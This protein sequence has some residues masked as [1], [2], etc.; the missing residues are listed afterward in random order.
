MH[1]AEDVLSQVQ[2][3][4][5]NLFVVTGSGQLSLLDRLQSNYPGFFA[6]GHIIS[7][8]DVRHGK[9]SPEP[10]LKGLERANVAPW[11]AVVVENA[12]LGVR[13]RGRAH[14]H[15]C[16]QYRTSARQRLA[17]RRSRFAILQHGSIGLSP[18]L[19]FKKIPDDLNYR[20][21]AYPCSSSLRIPSAL[22]SE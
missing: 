22:M 16:C 11:E 21:P 19:F 3:A 14:F 10:Y 7:S 15:D 17:Q 6:S 1:G 12:P 8:K 9:P 2:A 4:G 18:I 5:L 13:S 20:E